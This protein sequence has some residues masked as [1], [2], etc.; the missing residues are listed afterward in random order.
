MTVDH[1]GHSVLPTWIGDRAALGAAVPDAAGEGDLVL[2]EGHPGAAA[3]AEPAAGELRVEV[4]G[5]HL[6]AGRQPLQDR[7]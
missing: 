6:D 2:L 7:R 1:F 3:V 4:G 5:L